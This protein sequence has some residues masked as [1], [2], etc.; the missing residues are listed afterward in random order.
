M[1]KS[2]IMQRLKDYFR[3]KREID[4]TERGFP[5]NYEDFVVSW[6][7]EFQRKV[8]EE[9]IEAPKRE[10]RL[11]EEEIKFQDRLNRERLRKLQEGHSND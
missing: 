3:K 5:T 8:I 10:R 9:L 7:E 11:R 2:R 1:R 4:L 6:N